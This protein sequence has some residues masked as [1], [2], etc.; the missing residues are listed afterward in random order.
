[1]VLAMIGTFVNGSIVKHSEQFLR[2]ARHY[3]TQLNFAWSNK[4]GLLP[5]KKS[6]SS[7]ITVKSTWGADCCIGVCDHLVNNE[8]SSS[9]NPFVDD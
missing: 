9:I 6:S 3:A 8:R 5:S 1:M 7:H 2:W 4:F